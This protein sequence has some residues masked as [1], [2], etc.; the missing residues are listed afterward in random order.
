MIIPNAYI[1][2]A[3]LSWIASVLPAKKTKNEK[4][5]GYSKMHEDQGK[6]T[7]SML[8]YKWFSH[9]KITVGANYDD[10]GRDKVCITT[11]SC[12]MMVN[13][14]FN[15]VRPVA[16]VNAPTEESAARGRG[17]GMEENIQVENVEEVGQEEEVQAETTDVPPIDPVLP[18]QII[19]FLKGLVGPGVLPSVQATQAPANPPIA[20]TIPKV[21]G[22]VGNDTFFR[23]LLGPVMTGKE[24]EMLTKFLKLKPPVFHG[25][26]SEDVYEFIV[27]CYERL[28]KLG[29]VHQHG[30]QLQDQE[31]VEQI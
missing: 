6:A 5:F 16:P 12:G 13:T 17:R 14:R 8:T 18:Q 22:N 19:S 31:Q 27:Y 2:A 3:C 7:N 20:I 24:H 10:R 9:R 21:G 26:E 25:Y 1:S 11:V 28:H 30:V 15:G 4:D 29:I 23:P